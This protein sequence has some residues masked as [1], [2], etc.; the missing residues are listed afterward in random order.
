MH[1]IDEV[2]IHLKAGDGGAGAT[3]FRREKFVEFGGPD[4]GN[5]GRGGDIILEAEE[6][7]NTLVDF[8]YKQHFKAQRGENGMGKDRT[9][10]SGKNL[11]LRVPVGTQVYSEDAKFIIEDLDAPSKKVIIAKGG[12]GGLGNTNFKSST[13]QAPRRSTPG[14]EGGEI[15][16]WLKLKLLS[17]VG[18]IGMPNA[19]KST[20][21]STISAAKPKIADYPFTTL[22]PN[23]GVVSFQGKEFTVADIPG[24]IEGANKG[25]G[26]GHRFLKHIERCKILV[27]LIDA[28][29][30]NLAQSFATVKDELKQ[31]NKDILNKKQIVVLNKIDLLTTDQLEEKRSELATICGQELLTIS[32]VTKA[33]LDTLLHT[34]KDMLVEKCEN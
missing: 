29:Q 24:L 6:N 13:N 19:G 30:D 21:I 14:G 12:Q 23:L 28:S 18:L 25:I 1:F 9:G 17:E 31:Y 15:S 8:R 33:N 34:I 10:A 5:G 11:V 26:L 32:S 22:T 3:S 16:V 7:L 2:K 27:H 4:G 20:L